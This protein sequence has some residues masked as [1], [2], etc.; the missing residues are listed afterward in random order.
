MLLSI[1]VWTVSVGGGFRGEKRRQARWIEPAAFVGLVNFR[2]MQLPEVGAG[3]L[4]TVAAVCGHRLGDR[5][6]R[7][8]LEPA[9]RWG[10]AKSGDLGGIEALG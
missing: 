10:M 7:S 5:V 4:G 1:Y 3:G 6:Q 9:R 2:R 8:E